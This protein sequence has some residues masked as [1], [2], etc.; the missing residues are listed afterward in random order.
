MLLCRIRPFYYF[1]YLILTVVWCLDECLKEKQLQQ[2]GF[3]IYVL[4]VIYCT[5]VPLK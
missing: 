2:E 5:P 3:R 4:S 1:M